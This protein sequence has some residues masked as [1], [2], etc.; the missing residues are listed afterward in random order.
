MCSEV[1]VL[2]WEIYRGFTRKTF[3]EVGRNEGTR[4]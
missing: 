4:E 1:L 2:A 3:V